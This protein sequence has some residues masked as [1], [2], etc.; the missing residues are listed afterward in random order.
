MTTPVARGN[1]II[2][3]GPFRVVASERL[4][5]KDGVPV[6]LSP[7]TFDI[8]MALVSRPAEVVSKGD[9]IG[10][11]WPGI[12][13]EEGSLRFHIANLR[14]VLADG[15]D[16]ARYITTVTGRGYSFVAPISRPGAES[17]PPATLVS[18]FWHANLPGRP[19]GMV[20]REDDFRKLSAILSAV[21]FVTIVGSGGVGKTTVAVAIGHQLIDDFAGAVLFVDLSTLSNPDLVTTVIAS[22]LGLSVHTDDAAPSLVAHLRD[23]RV[24]LI[25]DTC[26]HLIEAT[27]KLASTI[28][29]A[30]PRVHILATSRE[31]LQVEGEHVYRLE[32][33]ECPLMT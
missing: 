10:Q 2:S 4:V 23:K 22:M 17:Q 29:A 20:G 6:K 16:G 5:T 15:R 1:D 26:E 7:R 24:L 27:A 32:P 30:A 13:V 12:A 18:G 28:F 25:L 8:L 19:T 33:L 31:T 3:F 9:L 14:K 11:A 21:R